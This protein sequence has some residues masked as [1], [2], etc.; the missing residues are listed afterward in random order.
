MRTAHPKSNSAK[1]RTGRALVTMLAYAIT[2]CQSTSPPKQGR[3]MPR[4]TP[5]EV[6]GNSV[7]ICSPKGGFDQNP[8]GTFHAT[9]PNRPENFKQVTITKP[10]GTNPDGPTHNG[11]TLP[12][13]WTR[14]DLYSHTGLDT[15][16]VVQPVTDPVSINITLTNEYDHS[17]DKRALHSRLHFLPWHDPKLDRI[18]FKDSAGTIDTK[19][20]QTAEGSG[21]CVIFLGTITGADPP[22]CVKYP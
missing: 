13:P 1:A 22:D 9:I 2:G 4:E 7:H 11:T 3:L 12:R 21:K 10:D 6:A 16:T 14:I 15:I 8:D 17:K 20:C 19:L 18:V 5:L